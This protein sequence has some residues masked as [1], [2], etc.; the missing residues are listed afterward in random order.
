MPV[1]FILELDKKDWIESISNVRSRP[2]SLSFTV[3]TK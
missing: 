3:T 2:L 1:I